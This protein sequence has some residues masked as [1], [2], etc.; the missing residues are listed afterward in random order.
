M[1]LKVIDKKLIYLNQ[2]SVTKDE[3]II[4][5]GEALFEEG[6]IERAYIDA[7]L[8]REKIATTYIGSML[9]IPHGTNESKSCVKR[10]GI[11]IFQY[12]EGV[13]FGEGNVAKLVI[14]IAAKGDE[15]LEILMQLADAVSD[16]ATL[17][18]LIQEN[19]SDKLYKLL[20]ENGLGGE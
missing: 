18:R 20:S 7:M 12:P 17:N 6:Y 8:E 1:T 15:H 3:A 13:D 10:T 2:S 16:D 11:S 9:A 5:A 14:G 19:D 4:K